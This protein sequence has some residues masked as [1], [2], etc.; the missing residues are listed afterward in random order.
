MGKPLLGNQLRDMGAGKPVRKRLI[1][2]IGG[3]YPKSAG[4]T[5]FRLKNTTG[6][7]IAMLVLSRAANQQIAIVG[8]RQVRR[9]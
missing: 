5:G 8:Q 3:S 9:D 7:G 4:Q 1:V 2:F 6:S